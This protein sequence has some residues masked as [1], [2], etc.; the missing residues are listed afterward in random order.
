MNAENA[1]FSFLESAKISVFQRPKMV[2]GLLPIKSNKHCRGEV[3]SPVYE[4]KFGRGHPALTKSI[5]VFENAS[6][7]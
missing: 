1:D 7:F 2:F 4:I 3:L 5:F 6:S